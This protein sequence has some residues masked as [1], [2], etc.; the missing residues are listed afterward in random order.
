MAYDLMA[1][2]AGAR[3][4]RTAKGPISRCRNESGMSTT[5]YG[6][7]DSLGNKVIF[8][9]SKSKVNFGKLLCECISFLPGFIGSIEIALDPVERSASSTSRAIVFEHVAL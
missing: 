5:F 2:D 9:I 8:E 7:V 1:Y 6:A 3:P 4:C